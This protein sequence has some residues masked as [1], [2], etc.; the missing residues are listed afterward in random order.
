[1]PT[2]CRRKRAIWFSGEGSA[3]NSPIF[4]RWAISGEWNTNALYTTLFPASDCAI[5]FSSRW[6]LVSSFFADA[7]HQISVWRYDA[8]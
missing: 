1:M 7:I 6:F 3:E 5:S 4:Q 8:G 2:G